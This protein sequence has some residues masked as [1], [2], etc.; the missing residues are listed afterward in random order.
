ML[1]QPVH[2]LRA[3]ELPDG[4]QNPRDR[5]IDQVLPDQRTNGRHDEERRDQHD[6]D[7]A[8]ASEIRRLQQRRDQ[9]A[10][11]HADQQHAAN[12]DQGIDH[13]G[14]E[15]G[16]GQEVMKILQSN[17]AVLAGI[18]QVVADH[19]EING[20]RQRHQHPQQQQR[21]GRADEEPAGA[22]P[23]RLAHVWFACR[24][25]D[26]RLGQGCGGGSHGRAPAEGRPMRAQRALAGSSGCLL[27]MP[28]LDNRRVS[29]HAWSI[30]A[31]R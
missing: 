7:D 29:F 21:N 27:G 25:G 22:E 31:R 19:R 10:E 3:E 2:R 11:H 13:S 14:H 8:A 15:A 30:A 6:A 5:V 16:V 1:R 9:Y 23:A 17:E 24:I 28:T 20:H 18:E 26:W 12:Q 4:R